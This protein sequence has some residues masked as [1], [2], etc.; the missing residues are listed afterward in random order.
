MCVIDML[1]VT[2]QLHCVACVYQ[3]FQVESVLW[4]HEYEETEKILNYFFSSMF[5][6]LGFLIL[7]LSN[8]A[9][10]S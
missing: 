9:F 10:V 5:V 8:S 6:S 4:S 1:S 7:V 3:L 2:T